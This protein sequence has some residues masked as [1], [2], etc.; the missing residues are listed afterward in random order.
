MVGEI[1]PDEKPCISGSEEF[2][3]IDVVLSAPA[4]KEDVGN[5][6]NASFHLFNGKYESDWGVSYDIDADSRFN[7]TFDMVKNRY[8]NPIEAIELKCGE[9]GNQDIL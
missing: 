4:I 7:E 6:Y 9:R 1:S 8:K 2:E 5:T 3:K